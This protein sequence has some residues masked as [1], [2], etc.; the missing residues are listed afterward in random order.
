MKREMT[1]YSIPPSRDLP[2]GRLA[3]RTA[4]LLGEIDPLAPRRL[5]LRAAAVA[6]AAAVAVALLLLVAPW[7]SA[8]SL[9]DQALAAV[10]QGEVLHVVTEYSSPLNSL[11]PVSL[12]TG[13]QVQVT[14]QQEVWLDS[15]RRLERIV[16]TIAGKRF[17]EVVITPDGWFTPGGPVYSCSWIAAHPVEATK[18]RVSCNEDM[19]NGTKPHHIPESPPTPLDPALAGFVDRYRSALASGQAHQTGKGELDGR[20]VVWLHI[21]SPSEDVAIDASSY[22]PVLVRN[23]ASSFSFRVTQIET[24]PYDASVFARPALQPAKPSIGE[25]TGTSEID[26]AQAQNL[27]G[28]RALWLGD[29]WKGLRLAGV[30][31]Q[32]LTTG[33]SP[34]SGRE[35]TRSTGV[36]LRYGGLV[37]REAMQCEIAY[38]WF[39]CD[40]PRMPT[41]DTMLVKG[42]GGSVFQRNGL[43]V[44]IW[45][46]GGKLDPVEVARALTA[47]PR[48]S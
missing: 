11:Q 8:P 28:G 4:H 31:R 40:D 19:D 6:A 15:D 22:K 2:P 18:A 1:G 42:P 3:E 5:P 32:E 41:G 10:G 16:A 26:I 47:A 29:Q 46:P 33:Y 27:L 30:Q 14:E 43:Y 21:A 23:D 34:L 24:Q 39:F 20:P 45:Q 7:T 38:G 36:T 17:H 13:K 35:P 9:T 37:I 44:S 25:V 12:R 48:S